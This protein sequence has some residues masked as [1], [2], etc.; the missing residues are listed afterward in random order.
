MSGA[1]ALTQAAAAADDATRTSAAWTPSPSGS[2]AAALTM[3]TSA[4][5]GTPYVWSNLASLFVP[6]QFTSHGACNHNL[7]FHLKDPFA[8]FASGAPEESRRKVCVKKGA[9]QIFATHQA[10]VSAPLQRAQ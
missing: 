1:A 10:A 8:G 6:L 7:L 4:A 9:R 5:N 3:E 2:G